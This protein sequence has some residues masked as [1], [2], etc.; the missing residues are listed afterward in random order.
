MLR[1]GL[2][3][4]GG[5]E[6]IWRVDT[7]PLCIYHNIYSAFPIF[8]C[9]EIRPAWAFTNQ[10]VLP[11]SGFPCFHPGLDWDGWWWGVEEVLDFHHAVYLNSTLHHRIPFFHRFFPTDIL[12]SR[13]LSPQK[14]VKNISTE[15]PSNRN[16]AASFF[17]L[18][19]QQWEALNSSEQLM[20]RDF[21]VKDTL[22][23]NLRANFK[24]SNNF[25]I[26]LYPI[27]I[28][29]RGNVLFCPNIFNAIEQHLLI[30]AGRWILRM[31][32]YEME[33]E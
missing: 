27:Q 9:F 29:G 31:K 25:H 5:E 30:L 10:F 4:I 33:I 18:G 15:L 17:Q 11:T 16:P 1:V 21:P 8:W 22:R 7:T 20:A 19:E 13:P 3:T 12:N 24:L 26:L 32:M 14:P 2:A 23:A 28:H 6:S